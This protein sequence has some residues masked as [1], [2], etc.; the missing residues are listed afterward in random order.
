MTPIV[1][2]A[3]VFHIA[4]LLIIVPLLFV[5]MGPVSILCFV[6]LKNSCTNRTTNERFGRKRRRRTREV[7]PNNAVS[8]TTS[9][10]AEKIIDDIGGPQE[11]N[12]ALRCFKNFG[13]FCQDSCVA[14]CSRAKDTIGYQEQIFRE[15]YENQRQRHGF[16]EDWGLVIEEMNKEI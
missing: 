6:H 12:G 9:F 14:E 1:T 8:T 11:V 2:N 4:N 3:I 15:L 10:L 7:D 5:I 16:E 13:F